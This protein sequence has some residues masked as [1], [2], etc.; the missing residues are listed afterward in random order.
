[1]TKKQEKQEE[2]PIDLNTFNS[3]SLFQLTPS[4]EGYGQTLLRIYVDAVHVGGIKLNSLLITGTAGL[5][6]SAC[7]FVRA[8]GIEEYAQ[9]DASLIHNA[10][11][12]YIF[13]FTDSF[14]GYIVTNIENVVPAVKPYFVDILQNKQFRPYNYGEQRRDIHEFGGNIIILTTKNTKKV[15]T[16]IMDCIDHV[17]GYCPYFR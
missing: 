2:Q 13:F 9:I 17:V 4:G 11:D 16:P 1:M 5:K 6:T 12:F 14:E 3:V 15:P 7:A 10:F 8:L